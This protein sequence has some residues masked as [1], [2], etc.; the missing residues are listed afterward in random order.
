MLLEFQ[1]SA[2]VLGRIVRNL[3]HNIDLC[4]EDSF[5]ILGNTWMID[6]I[7]VL[8]GTSLRREPA[9][10]QV[11]VDQNPVTLADGS[12]AVLAQPLQF[13][14]VPIA[15]LTGNGQNP[16]TPILSPVLT[17]LVDI[18]ASII[19]GD[20]FLD[21]GFNRIDFAATL[22]AG[23]VNA[24][25]SNDQQMIQDMVAA[26]IPSLHRKIDV[27]ESLESV[28]ILQ[29][30]GLNTT[31]A[32]ATASQ[33]GA[34]L[35]LRIE[36]NGAA[37]P[38]N[39]WGAFYA[40]YD[41]NLVGSGDWAMLIDKGILIPAIKSTISSALAASKDK[42]AADGGVGV[43]WT[44]SLGPVF[45]IEFSGEVIDACTCLWGEID[46][47]VDVSSTL[48]LQAG[49]NSSLYM[50]VNTT[51][52][53]NDLEV[54]CCALTASLFWP[55]V[56]LIYMGKDEGD[57]SFGTY[58]LGYVLSPI[59][60][61]FMA[62]CDMAG[63]QSITKYLSLPG[64][65]QKVDDEMFS[66]QWPFSPNMGAFG[67]TYHLTKVSAQSEGPVL[68]GT[69]AAVADLKDPLLAVTSVSQFTWHQRGSCSTGFAPQL[70]AI[71]EYANSA[72]GTVFKL[73]DVSVLEDPLHVFKVMTVGTYGASV[74]ATL[75]SAYVADPYP[76][77]LQ[78]VSNGGVRIITLAPAKDVTAADTA[79][80]AEELKLA[81]ALCQALSITVPKK[82][83][84]WMQ[85]DPPEQIV[86]EIAQIWQVVVAGLNQGESVDLVVR[87]RVM[88]TAIAY[89]RGVAQLSLWA[90]GDQVQDEI[91]L[92]LTAPG[93][94]RD[95]VDRHVS[96]KQARLGLMSRIGFA[97]EFEAMELVRDAGR[98]LLT[99][100]TSE[101]EVQYD[102]S[103]PRCPSLE[104]SRRRRGTSARDAVER[105]GLLELREREAA[106]KL[107]GVKRALAVT[108]RAGITRMVDV[109]EPGNAREIGRYFHTPW[110]TDA[111]QSR[112]TFVKLA[113]DGRHIAVYEV[114]RIVDV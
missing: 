24:L 39:D 78:I 89:G 14:L 63:N 4:V 76:C 20:A 25:S 21:F 8:P 107:A 101:G 33:D 73:C 36:V 32:G 83:I 60:F 13:E 69:V 1:L 112:Q 94:G 111:L 84:K 5:T 16:T 47:N 88:A 82:I 79:K 29:G 51:Y 71:V 26:R 59:G 10:A 52:D 48:V 92:V 12:K 68:S 102:V 40:T 46:I 61:T 11:I 42:F 113:A 15:S 6:R 90:E 37:D 97:G 43:S 55:I 91:G 44:P 64:G 53:A 77:K 45:E 96:V 85:P 62:V 9:G 109:S 35:L 86:V 56:G 104:S 100:R 114:Q 103:R 57:I 34:R 93:G 50:G 2:V 98:L 28:P 18:T 66:C 65:C 30:L 81:K 17:I 74:R 80:L 67:G 31:N 72:F 75:S 70:I 41:R 99:I 108:D 110:F 22:P 106:V 105:D 19:K 87:D 7:L 54:A 58:L 95:Q 3:L 49:Q 27:V 23:L 38:V